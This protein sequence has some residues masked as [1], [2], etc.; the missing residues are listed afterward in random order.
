VS[1]V[2]KV[3]GDKAV[4]AIDDFRLWFADRF[5]NVAA[6]KGP[7]EAKQ[8]HVMDRAID[9]AHRERAACNSVTSEWPPEAQM[10]ISKINHESAMELQ[11][12]YRSHQST[13]IPDL[14][15]RRDRIDGL[16]SSSPRLATVVTSSTDTENLPRR[17]A[18]KCLRQSRRHTT[19]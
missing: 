16:N 7:A 11:A 6:I 3:F 5:A 17:A 2:A 1:L 8:R 18:W 10:A 4:E 19:R 14:R 9:W 13:L 15:K 12:L